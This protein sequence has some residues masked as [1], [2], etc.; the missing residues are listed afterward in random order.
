MESIKPHISSLFND[1]GTI[2]SSS[3]NDKESLIITGVE[4]RDGEILSL[5]QPVSIYMYVYMLK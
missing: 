4:S 3:S 5:S 2:V 1:V